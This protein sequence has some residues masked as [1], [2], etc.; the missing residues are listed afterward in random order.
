MFDA[1]AVRQHH[2]WRL[3]EWH[4]LAQPVMIQ[5]RLLH[6]H[7]PSEHRVVL[8]YRIHLLGLLEKFDLG[9][10]LLPSHFL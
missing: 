5:I 6:L 10:V 1:A 3:L 4:R 2:S 8:K 9:D 7:V